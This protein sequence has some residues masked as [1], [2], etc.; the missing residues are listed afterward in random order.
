MIKKD[1]N[2][3]REGYNNGYKMAIENLDKIKELFN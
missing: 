1:V 3:L 2:K